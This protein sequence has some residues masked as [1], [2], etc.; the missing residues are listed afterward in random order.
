ME[1]P[2]INPIRT[3]LISSSS[4]TTS[5]TNTSAAGQAEKLTRSFGEVLNSLNESQQNADNQVS[6][7]SS[8]ENVD[9]HNL[10]ITSEENDINFRVTM[11]IRDR[12]VDAYREM[13]RMSV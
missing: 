12:L 8:G 5:T 9:L 6:L 7:L 1:I 13:M 2:G 3:S 10:M 4:P 11:A